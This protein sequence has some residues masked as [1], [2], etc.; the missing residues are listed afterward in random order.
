MVGRWRRRFLFGVIG[1]LPLAGCLP[2]SGEF[3]LAGSAPE[4]ELAAA[5]D[6][7]ELPP[8][9]AAQACLIMA[10][11]FERKGSDAFA[12]A[13]YEKA[14]QL[15][16]NLRQ[17]TRRLAVLYDRSGES[18]RAMSEYQEALKASPRDPNLLNDAGYCY[19]NRGQWSEAENYFRK[20]IALDGKHAR[21]WNNL[22]MALAQEGRYD[23]SLKAFQHVVSPGEAQANLAAILAAQGNVEE[24]KQAY[25]QALKL[26]PDL[27]SAQRGL[28]RLEHPQK[29]AATGG[30]PRPAPSL[31]EAGIV[32][33]PSVGMDAHEE[34]P[35]LSPLTVERCVPPSHQ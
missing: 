16:P 33:P 12:I 17:V 18:Q 23:E 30:A 11:S 4:R 6:K 13:E 25:G 8:R 31:Q 27:H 1:L 28:A 19:Y 34:I 35:D 2:S 29:T 22:G 3:F 26:E 14:R 32:P 21:A 24:A 9:E 20:A 5:A 7:S 15:D 10:A